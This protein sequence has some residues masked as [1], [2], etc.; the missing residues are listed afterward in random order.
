MQTLFDA[1]R[2][3]VYFPDRMDTRKALWLVRDVLDVD[4]LVAEA[5]E[6]VRTLQV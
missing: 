4:A 3:L 5:L 2:W 1:S 6:G